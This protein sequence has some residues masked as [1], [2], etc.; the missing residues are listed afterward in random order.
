[1]LLYVALGGPVAEPAQ[2]SPPALHPRNP[3][4]SLGLSDI[5]HKCLDHDP[6][7]RY[8]DAA[9]LAADLRRHLSDLPLRGVANRS[10]AERWSKWRRRRPAALSRRLILLALV[11]CLA[12]P[13]AALGIAYLQRVHEIE[14]ALA[15][16][17]L[18]LDH[19]QYAEAEDA[20]KRGLAL[21]TP[22][23]AVDRLRRTLGAQLAQVHQERQT[24]ELHR[25]S[26]VVRF[27]YGLDPPPAEEAQ[28]L[29][30]VGRRIWQARHVLLAR[31]G[32][33]GDHERQE[34]VRI[35]LLDLI[36]IWADLRVRYAAPSEVEEAR[37]EAVGAL[38]EAEALLGPSPSLDRELHAYAPAR[39]RDEPPARLAAQPRSAWEHYDL[40]RSYVRSGEL[41]LAAEQFRLGLDLRP[42][43]FWLNF[44][45]GLCNYRLK[46]FEAAANAFRVCVA[47]APG[48]AE[49][50]Y[51]RGLSYQALD[52][53]DSALGDYNRALT[54][55]P[56]LTDAALN[57][58]I[59]H[60]RQAQHA[61]ALADLERARSTTSNRDALGV[62]HYNLALVHLAR[63]DL[64]AAGAN[65]R[66][67]IRFGNAD[68]RELFRR[69]D[70]PAVAGSSLP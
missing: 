25:L 66:D 19:H 32:S 50:Y 26:E 24:E 62:I 8:P 9:A 59:I 45:E 22:L 48:T 35:D 38:Q 56:K 16:G 40:G 33:R 44:S 51:N 65:V 27:R 43:D 3:R 63:R 30:R 29:L 61:E 14:A 1:M 2:V 54:L 39:G 55:N 60:Y 47:L 28:S 52:Q 53:F 69:L 4:V 42:Q 70:R 67:A 49:C 5:I 17:R 7:G 57:L 11:A 20:L 21:T 64:A 6:R 36:I 23:L 18:H 15:Q 31:A 41:A 46:R 10:W 34:R 68:A 12:A 37:R 13:A 58:G